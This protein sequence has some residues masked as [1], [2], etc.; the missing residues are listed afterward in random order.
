[1]M[2]RGKKMLVGKCIMG[3]FIENKIFSNL[4]TLTVRHRLD[5]G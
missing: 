2:Y 4:T 1:M 3:K 5:D